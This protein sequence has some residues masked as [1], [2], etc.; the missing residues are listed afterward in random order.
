MFWVVPLRSNAGEATEAITR[1]RHAETRARI[2]EADLHRLESR[3][4]S[5][6]LGCQAMWELLSATTDLTNDD[7]LNRMQ[8]IDLRDGKQDGKMSNQVVTCPACDRPS[9]ARRSQCLYCGETIPGSSD[10]F[11]V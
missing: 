6:A 9:N 4:D 1:S 5:L 3:V 2:T 10:P 8:E 7:I 11:N